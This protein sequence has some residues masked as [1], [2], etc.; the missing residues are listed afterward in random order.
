MEYSGFRLQGVVRK[1]RILKPPHYVLAGIILLGAV[2]C[3]GGEASRSPREDGVQPNSVPFAFDIVV[4]AVRNTSKSIQLHAIDHDGDSLSFHIAPGGD[5]SHGMVVVDGAMCVYTPAQG[6]FG[7]DSFEY[8]A[9]DGKSESNV[10]TVTVNVGSMNHAPSAYGSS[11]CTPEDVPVAI[12]L[13]GNDPDG[14][15]LSFHVLEGPSHGVLAMDAMDGSRVSYTPARD[16]N[17]SDS[18]SFYVSDGEL[19]SSPEIVSIEIG[20]VNDPPTAEDILGITTE[21]DVPI[22]IVLG[23]SDIEDDPLTWHVSQPLH[24]SVSAPEGREVLYTPP[25]DYYGEDR[26][27]YYVNDGKSSSL[28]A[29]VTIIITP[30]NDPPVALPTPVNVKRDTPHDFTLQAYNPD[31]DAL[32]YIVEAEP[33]HGSLS[34]EGA[35]CRYTPDAGYTGADSFIFY[36]MTDHDRSEPVAVP[37]SVSERGVIFVDAEASGFGDGC[38][39]NSAYRSIQEAVDAASAGDQIWVKAG[40]YTAGEDGLPVLVAMKEHV[41]VYGG[42]RGNEYLLSERV[43]DLDPG[44]MEICSSILDGEESVTHVVLGAEGAALD[45]FIVQGGRAAG[46][47]IDDNGGGML[48]VDCSSPVRNCLF[49]N[50][51]A[52]GDGGAVCVYN[53]NPSVSRF[54]P[55][56]SNCR[57]ENNSADSDGGAIYAYAGVSPE[58]S[59]CTYTANSAVNGHGGGICAYGESTSI[60]WC[61]FTG[62][63]AVNGGGACVSY[64]CASD[65]VFAVMENCSFRDNDALFDGGGVYCFMSRLRIVACTFTMNAAGND[66]GGVYTEHERGVVFLD[67][68][69]NGNAASSMGGGVCTIRSG[70]SMEGCV[71]T[72]NRAN[73]GGGLAN[74]IYSSPILLECDFISNVSENGGNGGGIFNYFLSCPVLQ[75]CDFSSNEAEGHGGGMYSEDRSSPA[76]HDCSL[77]ENNAIGDGGGMFNGLYSSP[78]MRGCRIEGT[79]RARNGGGIFNTDRSGPHL[80]D[81]TI[82]NNI[83]SLGGGGVCNY[84]GSNPLF[85]N[86]L[87]IVNAAARGGGIYNDESSPGFKNCT[88]A[89]NLVHDDDGAGVNTGRGLYNSSMSAPRILNSVIWNYDYGPYV[90]V[91]EDV[92]SAC[93]ASYSLIRLQSG[94]YPGEGNLNIDPL[95]AGADD[96]RMRETLMLDAGDPETAAEICALLRNRESVVNTPDLVRPDDCV[97]DPGYHY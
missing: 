20:P 8:R 84:G 40:V 13:A 85:I 54:S 28:P 67:C 29:A 78:V 42:F 55:V 53:S 86:C 26:F 1:M 83:A 50:N 10:A 51:R 93:E 64:G 49:R 18:F 39:W 77:A 36:V 62:N 52:S 17:G 7:Q 91:V 11:V 45:G 34:C 76:L 15:T 30:V 35:V 3:A 63:S 2:S 61:V 38:F 33:R 73:N 46:G 23:G 57:F 48:S 31:N 56:F 43:L 21:E 68:V 92:D 4:T 66:G 94:V 80:S 90:A 44:G 22:V 37:V 19:L 9:S 65:T 70:P 96:Y 88:I 82:R 6:F 89:S 58:I 14:D 16:Y 12:I 95:F 25:R 69:F 97:V 32:T 27:H 5:P 81:C 41:D 60:R 79:V 24:G 72:G 87:V 71:F 59:E 75:N 74:R 47:G